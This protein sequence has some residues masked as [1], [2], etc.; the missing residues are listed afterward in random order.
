MVGQEHIVENAGD[1]FNDD[2]VPPGG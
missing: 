1:I 2:Y